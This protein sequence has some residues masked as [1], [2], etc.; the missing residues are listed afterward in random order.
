MDL[1]YL[2]YA[3][4]AELP[5]EVRPDYRTGIR[6]LS[7]RRDLSA[8]G[9]YRREGSLS[10]SAWLKSLIGET[11]HATFAWDDPLPGMVEMGG[12]IREKLSGLWSRVTRR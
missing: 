7:L 11:E 6:W 2:A 4:E 10:T 3:R 1:G 9:D 12:I 5:F 8:F